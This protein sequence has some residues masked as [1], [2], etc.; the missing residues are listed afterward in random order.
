MIWELIPG[1]TKTYPTLVIRFHATIERTFLE[2][3]RE[4]SIGLVFTESYHFHSLRP[5]KLI[6]VADGKAFWA[7]IALSI[8]GYRKRFIFLPGAWLSSTF[9]ERKVP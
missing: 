2:I 4:I 1:E 6:L 3:R 7:K 8:I 5:A 9:G